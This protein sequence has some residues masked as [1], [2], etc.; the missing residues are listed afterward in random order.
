M[1]TG[2]VR[3]ASGTPMPTGST[4]MSSATSRISGI[5]AHVPSR[6]RVSWTFCADAGRNGVSSVLQSDTTCSAVHSTVARRS[7]LAPSPALASFAS[8]HGSCAAMYALASPTTCIAA[9]TAAR[10]RDAPRA[11]PASSKVRSAKSRS[12][13]SSSSKAPGSGTSPK[14]LCAMDTVRLT[15]LP[16]PLA[17]SLFTRRT[18]S[19]HVKSVSWFSGPA[20]A[21]K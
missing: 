13:R 21:M 10:K 14:F 2:Y 8:F 20:T 1:I 3:P 17:S 19:S 7:R 9:V 4:G 6:P 12:A 5:A 18:N 16:Q 11:F 15:R